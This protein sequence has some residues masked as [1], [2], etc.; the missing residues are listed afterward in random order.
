MSKVPRIARTGHPSEPGRQPCIFGL[1][2]ESREGNLYSEARQ[3]GPATFA[4]RAP[5]F[6]DNR[7]ELRRIQ[8]KRPHVIAATHEEAIRRKRR[9]DIPPPHSRR[10]SRHLM[11]TPP[12]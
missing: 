2:V 3:H 5:C 4:N 10:T 12:V 7:R 1:H 9:S 6:I 8:D 11:I